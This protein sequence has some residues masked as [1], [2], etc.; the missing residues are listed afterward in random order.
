MTLK[1]GAT[2]H[3]QWQALIPLLASL[4]WAEHQNANPEHW[5]RTDPISTEPEDKHLL[6]HARPE[7]A[8]AYAIDAGET[9]AEAAEAWRVAAEQL[10]NF[11]KRNRGTSVVMDVSSCL[12]E[13]ETC[14]A[15]LAQ[16]LGLA[17]EGQIPEFAL[18]E[19]PNP[20]NQLLANQLIAQSDELS[21]LLAELEACTLPLG[22][23]TFVS[24]SI[25]IAELY[26]ELREAQ[27]DR[28]QEQ[29]EEGARLLETQQRLETELE[30]SR[31]DHAKT[32]KVLAETREENELVLNQLFQVQEELERYHNDGKKTDQAMKETE[33]ALKETQ[34]A[35]NDTEQALKTAE[36]AL[37]EKDAVISAANKRVRELTNAKQAAQQQA[38]KEQAEAYDRLAEAHGRLKEDQNKVL[39]ERDK[40]QKVLEET[41]EEN[42][43]ILNQLFSVQEELERY[44]LDGK[45][46]DSKLQEKDAALSAANKK[47]AKLNKDNKTLAGERNSLRKKAA[48]RKRKIATLTAENTGLKTSLLELQTST[49]WRVTKPLRFLATPISKFKSRRVRKALKLIRRSDL[50]DAQWYLTQYPDVANAKVS[51]EEHYLRYGA[52]EQRNPSERFCTQWYLKTNTD[53]AQAGINP[54]VH[55]I[56]YGR[57]EG[58]AA[59]PE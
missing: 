31:R 33:Q 29:L 3:S 57:K 4:G 34:Q 48:E 11:Y 59:L 20:V 24:P 7:L 15:A 23:S 18:P 58:R 54:L 41:R 51:P 38:E 40:A 10:L 16:Y 1:V 25:H 47:I 35:L 52:H 53:V 27:P 42:D 30:Q 6:L 32:K 46:K 37:K 5:Y 17:A 28:A 12:L 22:D 21:S 44:Y 56:S 8:V 26:E 14:V 36:Q 39:A 9:P 49:S 50:F 2:P 45:S 13:P 43:L 55:Y 19:K